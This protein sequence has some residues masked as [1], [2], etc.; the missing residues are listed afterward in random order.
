MSG[1]FQ[2]KPALGRSEE[3]K[4]Q[5]RK[6]QLK[7]YYE[8]KKT[9]EGRAKLKEQRQKRKAK[10]YLIEGIDPP[11]NTAE[12]AIWKDAVAT[13]KKNKD[14]KGRF[15][16]DSGYSKSM[17]GKDFYSGKIKIKDNQTGKTFSFN[18]FKNYINNNAESFGIEGYRDAMKPYRQKYSY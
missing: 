7:K 8:M 15:S 14:G 11:A 5:R 16:F 4:E 17:K 12:E 9:E 2:R 3:S 6:A 18:T 1:S 13:A 10:L